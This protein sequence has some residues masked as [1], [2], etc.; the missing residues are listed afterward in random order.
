[1]N[2]L[3]VVVGHVVAQKPPEVTFAEDDD[4]IQKLTPAGSDP[5]FGER[6]LPGTAVRRAYGFK[7]QVPDRGCDVGGE[8]R[9][10]VVDE[11]GKGGVRGECLPQLLDRPRC[12][13][14]R[15][16]VEVDQPS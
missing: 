6:V 16:D 11:E 14:I 13:G 12:G 5:S 4:V 1:V 9:V 2:P 15:R 8:A 7:T 10:A 3:S